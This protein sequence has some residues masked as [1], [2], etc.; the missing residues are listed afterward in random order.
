[1]GEMRNSYKLLVGKPEV[2]RPLRRPRHRWEV[3]IRIDGWDDVD[4][5]HLAQD[6]NQWWAILITV[7]NLQVP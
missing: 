7:M 6:K 1:M 4:W 3:D 2:K 5:V